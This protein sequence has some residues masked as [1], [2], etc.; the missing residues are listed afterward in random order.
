MTFDS[1]LHPLRP[2]TA[3]NARQSRPHCGQSPVRGVP[4]LSSI[5]TPTPSL[6]QLSGSKPRTSHLRFESDDACTR[7]TRLLSTTSV[8]VVLV[9][10]KWPA[11]MSN[12]MLWLRLNRVPY[13]NDAMPASRLRSPLI[14]AGQERG[15]ARTFCQPSSLG[16]P[17]LV[18]LGPPDLN[19]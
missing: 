4:S 16:S 18:P 12:S 8:L 7:T 10:R 13:E 14:L 9:P 2:R 17:V 6:P 15:Y 1:P 11:Y 3:K 19:I 5:S